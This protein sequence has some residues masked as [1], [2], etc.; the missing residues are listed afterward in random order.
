M[1]TIRII[2]IVLLILSLAAGGYYWYFFVQNPTL[3]ENGEVVSP[4]EFS[5]FG[6]NT[7]VNQPISQVPPPQ[8]EPGEVP[9]QPAEP[10]KMPKLRQIS[11]TPIAGVGASSTAS[12]SLVRYMDR[13]TGHVYEVDSLLPEAK[14]LSNTTL[15]KI[16]EAYWN[17]NLNA[18]VLRYLRNET[19]TITNFYAEVRS[20]GT[21][22]TETPFEVKGRFLVPDIQQVAISP[23]GNR[24]FTWNIENSRG[25]G[26]VSGFDETAKVKVADT[27]MTQVVLD[28]PETNTVT[29]QTKASSG[30]IG[31]LYSIDIRNGVMNKVLG[32]VRGLVGKVSKDG[33]KVFYSSSNSNSIKTYYSDIKTGVN[34]EVIFKTLADK[35]V[36]S[37]LRKNEVYCAVPT[38]IASGSYPDDWYSGKISFIDQIW[39][40]DT[41]TGEV[42]LLANLLNLS[43]KLMDATDLILDPKEDFLY[44]TNKRDLTLWSLD[45]NQ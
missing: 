37:T 19:D 17:K 1:K 16:Y 44:F 25:V 2:S 5:P 36:W 15:P 8:E 18:L 9:S 13:G 43:N 38:E 45:L 39:H 40:L 20:T 29:I 12:S 3:D 10:L 23:M 22:T 21:S 33:L 7:V 14:K 30:L 41:T 27:P 32:D 4:F 24:I 28:W 26:Y 34:Q 35:C 11:T 6:R 31:Y 42:H